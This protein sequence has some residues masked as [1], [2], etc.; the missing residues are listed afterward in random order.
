MSSNKSL[1]LL[2]KAKQGD[3]DAK[4]ELVSKNLGLV[5]SVAKRF[6][7]RGYDLEELFQ[8]GSIGLLKAID[9]FDFSYNVQFST[10][11]VPMILGE[12]R[13]F[14]RDDN[15]IKVSRS[16]KELAVKINRT[17]ECMEKTLH[18]E[19]TINELAEE[20]KI[21]PEEL[22]MGIESSQSLIS[23]NEVAYQDDGSPIHYI[24][25]IESEDELSQGQVLDRIALKDAL[26]KL[27]KAERQLIVLRYFEDKTQ[28]EVAKIL[29]IS[30]VQVSRLERKI[31]KKIKNYM[32]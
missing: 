27:N 7:N 19:P 20:M 12:I 22:V 13:R 8:T 2:K 1:E 18:R 31:L 5:W 32:I 15:P 30:Q 4:A 16:L 11:A 9:K 6:T 29:G 28:M 26:F 24:D 17:K 23:L 14:L 3:E 10:Y 21:S 25:Q